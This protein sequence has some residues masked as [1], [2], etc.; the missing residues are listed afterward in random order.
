MI[1][2]NNIENLLF[3]GIAIAVLIPSKLGGVYAING[4][5]MSYFLLSGM[6]IITCI[7]SVIKVCY[8]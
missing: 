8:R 7:L 5:F 6:Y 2:L 4:L 1:Y 3:T